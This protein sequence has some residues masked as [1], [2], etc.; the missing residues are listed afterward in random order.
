MII[1]IPRVFDSSAG[2]A[3]IDT[4]IGYTFTAESYAHRF[5][6]TPTGDAL[7]GTVSAF[8]IRADGVTVL[9]SG[10]LANGTAVIDLPPECY[11]VPGKFTLTIFVT[12][13][14][15]RICIYAAEATVCAASSDV[16]I[17]PNS[18]TPGLTLGAGTADEVTITAA[19]LRQLL[20][21]L[22]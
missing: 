5:I 22:N 10:S 4:L 12:S 18:V 6:I 8:F 3:R 11:A 7:T 2:L 21:L 1:T 13:G 14:T 15:E 16:V 17:T 19:Q 20:A 9:I